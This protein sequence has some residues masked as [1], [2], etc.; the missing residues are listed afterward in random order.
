MIP[1]LD[2]K[3]EKLLVDVENTYLPLSE[4]AWAMNQPL[5]RV[6]PR[7]RNTQTVANMEAGK[8][9]RLFNRHR[10]AYRFFN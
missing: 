7:K 2:A 8:F 5:Q 6:F 9:R 10:T 1:V 4:E 3:I